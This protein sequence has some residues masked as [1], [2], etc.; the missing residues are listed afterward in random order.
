MP[1]R[2]LELGDIFGGAFRAV[3]FAPLTM[4]GLTVVVLMLAQLLGLGAGFV[5]ARQ[6]G[7]SFLPV[8]DADSRRWPCSRGRRSQAWSRIR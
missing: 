6:F 1:P 5:L 4:F 8:E 2:P 7:P 3:R